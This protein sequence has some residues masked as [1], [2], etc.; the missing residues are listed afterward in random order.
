MDSL[1][2]EMKDIS[3]LSSMANSPKNSREHNWKDALARLQKRRHDA[4]YLFIIII[5]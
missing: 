4:W 3:S 5:L 1:K 2:K